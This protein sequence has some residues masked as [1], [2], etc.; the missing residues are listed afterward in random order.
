MS[1]FAILDIIKHRHK[2]IDPL[3]FRSFF[4]RLNTSELREDNR[5]NTFNI[6]HANIGHMYG[7]NLFKLLLRNDIH[8][9]IQ[10]NK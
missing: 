1:F 4:Q 2:H 8:I 5:A 9:Y 3:K 6:L 7:N 10:L